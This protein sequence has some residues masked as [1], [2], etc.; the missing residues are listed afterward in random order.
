MGAGR[1]IL[2]WPLTGGVRMASP[3][4]SNAVAQMAFGRGFIMPDVEPVPP[5]WSITIVSGHGPNLHFFSP[6]DPLQSET[7]HERQTECAG[8]RRMRGASGWK[9]EKQNVS[10][11]RHGTSVSTWR[12]EG[13]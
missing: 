5:E 1:T 7:P 4:A 6:H 2:V 9:N 13:L 10:W 11:H 3:A 12:C 8:I